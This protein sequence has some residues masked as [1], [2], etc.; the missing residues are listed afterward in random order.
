MTA[1]RASPERTRSPNRIVGVAVWLPP[2]PAEEPESWTVWTQEWI[3]SLR[4]VLNNIRFLGRGGLNLRRYRIW[5]ASQKEA[6]E[7]ILWDPRGYY[8]CTFLAVSAEAR[9]QG[10]GRRLV[11]MVTSVADFEGV[12]CYLESSKAVPNVAIYRKM[13]FEFV[14]E[15]K[16]VDGDDVCTVCRFLVSRVY[17]CV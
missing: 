7:D 13:G 11:D 12:P 1:P 16:S 5:K 8:F 14:R 17:S 6:H 9:G 3:L 10:V 4:Q 15:V 2:K